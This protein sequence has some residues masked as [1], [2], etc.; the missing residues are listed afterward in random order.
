MEVVQLIA[1][2]K[3]NPL[4]HRL[5]A[6]AIA[7]TESRHVEWTHL[8]PRLVTEPIQKWLEKLAKLLFPIRRA[9]NHSRPLQKPNTH[10]SQKPAFTPDNALSFGAVC[11]I[12][13]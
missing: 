13:I 6:F 10:E 3:P 1:V 4:R 7:W 11:A 5:N 12:Q 8:S 2:A 9:A